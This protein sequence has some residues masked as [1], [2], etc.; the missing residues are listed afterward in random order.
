MKPD[1]SQSQASLMLLN[2]VTGIIDGLSIAS[3]DSI[4]SMIQIGDSYGL[5]L[6]SLLVSNTSSQAESVLFIKDSFDLQMNNITVF[7]VFQLVA[8]VSNSHISRAYNMTFTN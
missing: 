7:N 4:S 1:Y 3:S 8:Q 2:N 6:V 5:E